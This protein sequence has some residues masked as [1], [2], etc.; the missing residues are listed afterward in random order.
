MH[1]WIVNKESQL[2]FKA[3]INTVGGFNTLRTLAFFLKYLVHH[4]KKRNVNMWF[5]WTAPQMGAAQL[6]WFALNVLTS[7]FCRWTKLVCPFAALCGSVQLLSNH[8]NWSHHLAGRNKGTSVCRWQERLREILL[9]SALHSNHCH[10]VILRNTGHYCVA[11]FC[12]GYVWITYKYAF[13]DVYSAV[14][15]V[16]V[17]V[18]MWGC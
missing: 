2:Q 3:T 12:V 11:R 17:G 7:L 1:F 10:A 14:H 13:S 6:K 4:M 15:D 5:W 8:N 9:S 16:G 18:C